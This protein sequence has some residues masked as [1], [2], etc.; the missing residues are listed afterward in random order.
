[1]DVNYV[2]FR[3]LTFFL[4]LAASLGILWAAVALMLPRPPSEASMV[5]EWHAA[6]RRAQFYGAALA[7]V[8]CFFIALTFVHLEGGVTVT[9]AQGVGRP[10]HER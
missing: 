4:S 7:V 8:A 1:M 3:S 10:A 6:T 2:V 5:P 9:I